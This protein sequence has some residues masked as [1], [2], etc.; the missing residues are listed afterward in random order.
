MDY[1]ATISGV[2]YEGNR[3]EFEKY[4]KRDKWKWIGNYLAEKYL[5]LIPPELKGTLQIIK[6]H[7]PGTRN[8]KRA[9]FIFKGASSTTVHELQIIYPSLLLEQQVV[10]IDE[11]NRAVILNEIDSRF[12]S[13]QDYLMSLHKPRTAIRMLRRKWAD[14][15]I[16]AG[17]SIDIEL[18]ISDFS[19]DYEEGEY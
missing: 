9:T 7:E 17:F 5:W 19:I 11:S 10:K 1:T 2:E 14:E 12:K 6:E 15:L 3:K 8:L 13:D 4:R 16:K 18:F